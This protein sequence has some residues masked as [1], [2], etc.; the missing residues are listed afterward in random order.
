MAEFCVLLGSLEETIAQAQDGDT[1]V[2]ASAGLLFSLVYCLIRQSSEALAKEDIPNVI[3]TQ[4]QFFFK[5]WGWVA[6]T[7]VMQ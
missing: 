3:A 5:N 6:M 7:S 2:L 1:L 4:P